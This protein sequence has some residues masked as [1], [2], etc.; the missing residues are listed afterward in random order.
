MTMVRGTCAGP[1]VE[2]L[3]AMSSRYGIFLVMGAVEKEG[4]TLYCTILFFDPHRGLLGKHRKLMPT[5][6]ERFLWG[7]GEG[8]GVGEEGNL[9]VF[10]TDVGRVGGVICW[11]N[12]MPLLRAAM[13]AKGGGPDTSDMRMWDFLC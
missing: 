10:E 1:Q 6:G 13:Y 8:G 4:G 3:A 7:F 2:S 12:R 11:E 5:A 9:P